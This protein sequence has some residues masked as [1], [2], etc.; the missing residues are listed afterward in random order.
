[1]SEGIKLYTW[2]KILLEFFHLFS[3]VNKFIEINL[4]LTCDQF[5]RKRFLQI[6]K[7]TFKWLWSVIHIVQS[8]IFFFKGV[9]SQ[10]L[11]SPH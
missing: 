7:F 4:F 6:K 8:I 10:Y 1:M 5:L 11:Q 9:L 3:Y 2:K